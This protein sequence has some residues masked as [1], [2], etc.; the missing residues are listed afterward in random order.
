MAKAKPILRKRLKDLKPKEK[1][2]LQGAAKPGAGNRGL[3]VPG[4]G[5]ASSR[6]NMPGFGLTPAATLKTYRLMSFHPTLTLVNAIVTAPVR[7]NSWTWMKSKEAPDQVL[8]AAKD[9]LNPLRMDVVRDMCRAIQFECSF[10]EKI[11]TRKNGLTTFASL[12][13][14]ADF[15]NTTI[16]VDNKGAITGLENKAYG[17]NDKTQLDLNECFIFRNNPTTDF[18]YGQSRFQST[19]KPWAN[20]E[21]VGERLAQY[22]RK[23]CGIILQCHYPDGQGLDASGAAR[24]NFWLAED[25]LEQIGAGRSV[26]IP[27]KFASF[28]GGDAGLLTP[29]AIEKALASAGKSDWVLSAFDPGGVDHSAGLLAVLAYYDQC[30]FRGYQVPE[31]AGLEAQKGGMGQSDA[32]E[33]GDVALLGSELLDQDIAVAFSKG[34]IDDFLEDNFGIEARGS[35][36]VEPAPLADNTVEQAGALVTAALASPVLSTMMASLIDWNKVVE[37]SGMPIAKQVNQAILDAA[38]QS[39]Q[40]QQM[41]MLRRLILTLNNQSELHDGNR[42]LVA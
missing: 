10:F 11:R 7:R 20:S 35:V 21:E 40:Q 23:I 4:N 39:P 38:N 31:R 42:R 30:M 41:A 26:A 28:L 5:I 2:G 36:W 8:Q 27:N 19:L 17:T 22:L 18:F 16:T 6:G 33:H 13:P 15:P 3:G 9:S 25:L 29:A 12:K 32:S 1:T 37:D 24:P 14:L 34:V